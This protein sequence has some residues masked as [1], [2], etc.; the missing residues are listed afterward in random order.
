MSSIPVAKKKKGSICTGPKKIGQA[1]WPDFP[2]P[3][4][5]PFIF[6]FSNLYLN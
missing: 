3:T 5:P 6:F 4:V 1:G 2:D